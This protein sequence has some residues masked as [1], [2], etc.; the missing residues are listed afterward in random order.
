MITLYELTRGP[1]ALTS[2]TID[3]EWIYFQ[4]WARRFPEN[5][6]D[7][8]YGI[9][10]MGVEPKEENMISAKDPQE[11]RGKHLLY[12]K[13][14]GGNLG[15]KQRLFIDWLERAEGKQ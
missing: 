1:N 13:T 2:K 11:L 15:H 4:E 9:L 8:K 5:T 7:E 3:E 12:I 10:P 14:N 6:E